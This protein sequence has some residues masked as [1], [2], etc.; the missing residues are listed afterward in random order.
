[1]SIYPSIYPSIHPSTYVIDMYLEEHHLSPENSSS[2]ITF[3]EPFFSL[4]PPYDCSGPR[5]S[6]KPFPTLPFPSHPGRGDDILPKVNQSLPGILH[7]RTNNGREYLHKR[8]PSYKGEPVVTSSHGP[9]SQGKSL[10]EES[11]SHKVRM[12]GASGLVMC[13]SRFQS[14]S[15]SWDDLP[16][17]QLVYVS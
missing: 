14:F 6:Q 13:V 17:S 9:T 10:R 8:W 7:I 16:W 2:H 3:L 15:C 4:V 1:M 5:Q 11:L 12:T